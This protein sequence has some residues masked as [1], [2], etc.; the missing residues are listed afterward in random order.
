M[1]FKQKAEQLE[2]FL[3]EEFKK[4]L[5]IVVLADKSIIYKNYKIKQNKHGVW[6]LRYLGTGDIINSFRTKTCALLAAKFY[7]KNNFVKYNA[8]LLLDSQYWSNFVD[9]SFFKSRLEKTNDYEKLDLFR[10][11]FDLANA[12]AKHYKNEISMMFKSQF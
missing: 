7:E 2:K 4:Q 11:R 10:A 1:N 9:T 5:P 3:E 12:R 6:L 8:V